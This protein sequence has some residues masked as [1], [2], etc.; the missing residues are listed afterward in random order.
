MRVQK[1][2]K[3]SSK[4][5]VLALTGLVVLVTA[6]F[7]VWKV[8]QNYV[9]PST[10]FKPFG[11][12]RIA[13]KISDRSNISTPLKNSLADTDSADYD[14]YPQAIKVD[15]NSMLRIQGQVQFRHTSSSNRA[16]KGVLT[17]RLPAS[18][19]Y[20]PDRLKFGTSEYVFINDCF[21][22]NG[23][24]DCSQK[25][26]TKVID[27]SENIAKKR[28]KVSIEFPFPENNNDR[29]LGA[30][31]SGVKRFIAGSS[32]Y[33]YSPPPATNVLLLRVPRWDWRMTFKKPV[34]ES[35]IAQ[36][37]GQVSVDADTPQ[38]IKTN[39]LG[40]DIDYLCS[41]IEANLVIDN[42]TNPVFDT[43]SIVQAF[44][45]RFPG[46]V[47]VDGNVGAGGITTGITIGDNSILYGDRGTIG[48]TPVEGG[49]VPFDWDANRAE[50]EDLVN[51]A[52]PQRKITGNL[53]VGSSWNLNSTDNNPENNNRNTFSTP[54]E[55]QLWKVNGNLT[56]EG[57]VFSGSGTLIVS[58]NVEANSITCS[59]GTRLGIIATGEITFNGNSGTPCGAY[60]AYGNI[61]VQMTNG[62]MN[63]IL[64]A[65]NNITFE[66]IPIGSNL[67]VKYDA[68]FGADPTV[69]FRDLLKI[70]YKTTS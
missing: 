46:I 52:K 36:V 25:V 13:Y 1:F 70:I 18:T 37:V 32:A 23:V 42:R 54:P 59:S 62:T 7:L 66:Y 6:S 17:I 27:G 68:V 24:G 5:V 63:T 65:G 45:L 28:Y 57:T 41:T 47:N 60:F 39:C 56:L 69:L 49:A 61:K 40:G 4:V 11:G 34:T 67:N 26:T 38:L 12:T 35:T 53:T 43:L 20:T 14:A 50:V 29:V 30:I 55:G 10:N 58:G 44:D 21:K 22:L 33:A 64:I 15:R 51:N 48:G 31:N 3:Y 2:F 9:S 8:G 16:E 19:I